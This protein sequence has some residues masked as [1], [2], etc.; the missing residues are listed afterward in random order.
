MVMYLFVCMCMDPPELLA[1]ANEGQ[2]FATFWVQLFV[3]GLGIELRPASFSSQVPLAT[4]PPSQL[5][6]ENF[7]IIYLLFE[8]E[9]DRQ[10]DR[11]YG[12]IRVS[13]C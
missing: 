6:P 2:M 11:L 1:T 10:R 5:P 3:G 12:Y 4:E 7:N 9:T 8:S 13:C